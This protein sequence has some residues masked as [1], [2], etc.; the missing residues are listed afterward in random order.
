MKDRWKIF[1]TCFALAGV[2]AIIIGTLAGSFKKVE[3]REYGILY[4][5]LFSTVDT[6]AAR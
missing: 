5:T 1:W 3:L 6:S 4:Y 2:L